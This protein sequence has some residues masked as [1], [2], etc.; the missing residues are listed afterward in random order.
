MILSVCGRG[1]FPERGKKSIR[2]IKA[3]VSGTQVKALFAASVKVASPAGQKA[4]LFREPGE[5]RSVRGLI[6]GVVDF[7]PRKAV[8]AERGEQFTQLIIAHLVLKRVGQNRDCPVLQEKAYTVLRRYFLPRKQSSPISLRN[9][10]SIEE[11]KPFS[12][13]YCAKWARVTTVSGKNDR[14]SS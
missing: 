13:I 6:T 8:S 14:S 5:I 7:D 10:S 3:A 1:F 2:N 11:M 4:E 9:A 12:S